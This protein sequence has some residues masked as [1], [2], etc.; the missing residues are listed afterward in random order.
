MAFATCF[1]DGSRGILKRKNFSYLSLYS[2]N[3]LDKPSEVWYYTLVPNV[4]NKNAQ[5]PY[6]GIFRLTAKIPT[7]CA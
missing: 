2:K 6:G 4:R 7:P 5:Y 3:R 1:F